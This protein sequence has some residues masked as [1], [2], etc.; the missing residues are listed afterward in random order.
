MSAEGLEIENKIKRCGPPAGAEKDED[1]V[2][3]GELATD[4]R[5]VAVREQRMTMRSALSL[6]VVLGACAMPGHQHSKGGETGPRFHG[7]VTAVTPD[8]TVSN[9]VAGN[10]GASCVGSNESVTRNGNKSV[11]QSVALA[12]KGAGGLERR[13]KLP[14]PELPVTPEVQRELRRFTER[15]RSF[16]EASVRSRQ[17]YYDDIREV[18]RNEGVPEELLNV[19]AIESRFSPSALSPRGARGMWQ[20]IRST[21]ELYG[22]RTARG[23]DERLD[24]VR[25]AKAAARHLKDLYNSLGDWFLALAAYNAGLGSVTRAL[26]RSEVAD[27]WTLARAGKLSRETADY[28]P[29]FIAVTLIIRDLEK[30]GFEKPATTGLG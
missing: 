26:S 11:Q 14:R 25:S 29:R 10:S 5:G 17:K 16:I 21:A 1:E 30:Y 13:A 9:G 15:D 27:F 7:P 19:A 18:F 4:A 6:L 12:R 8:Q 3:A 2:V 20:F 24:P 28:V 23:K 22:L